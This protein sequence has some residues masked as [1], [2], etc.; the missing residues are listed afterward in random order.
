MRAHDAFD[1]TLLVI[2]T[3]DGPNRRRR[4]WAKSHLPKPVARPAC[5]QAVR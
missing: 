1:L 2:G 4:A 5:A 3:D